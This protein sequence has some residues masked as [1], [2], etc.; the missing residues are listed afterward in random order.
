MKPS[1][2]ILVISFCIA[3]SACSTDPGNKKSADIGCLS[4]E[5]LKNTYTPA[6]LFQSVGKCVEQEK[7][8]DAV[9]LFTLAGLYGRFDTLRVVDQSTHEAVMALRMETIEAMD[10]RKKSE[11]GELAK[12]TLGRH[13]GLQDICKGVIQLGP[14]KYYPRYMIQYG[15]DVPIVNKSTEGLNPNFDTGEAWKNTLDVYLRCADNP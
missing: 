13:E 12:M 7:Y 1:V 9:F 6:D 5:H 8:K 10:T 2:V 4:T 11:F 14:P 15:A 3:L